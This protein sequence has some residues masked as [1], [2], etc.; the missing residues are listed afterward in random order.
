[1]AVNKGGIQVFFGSKSENYALMAMVD[2]DE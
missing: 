1:V 2:G